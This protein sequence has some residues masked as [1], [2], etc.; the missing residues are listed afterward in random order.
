MTARSITVPHSNKPTR[1]FLI[2]RFDQL[3]KRIEQ[4]LVGENQGIGL[5]RAH[6]VLAAASDLTSLD[7]DFVVV[8]VDEMKADEWQ[9]LSELRRT[10]PAHHFFGLS[11]DPATKSQEPQARQACERVF[12]LTTDLADLR[13]ELRQP[14]R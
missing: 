13:Q 8:N 1:V 11:G 10:Y 5:E 12:P 7:A 4:T 2:E 3:A 9:T 14:G 6:D